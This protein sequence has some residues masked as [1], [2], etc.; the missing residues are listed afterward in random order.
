MKSININTKIC[1]FSIKKLHGLYTFVLEFKD[2]RLILVGENGTG[3][4]TCLKIF[5]YFITGQ[6]SRLSFYDFESLEFEFENANKINLPKSII[7]KILNI[8]N[9]YLRQLPPPVRNSIMHMSERGSISISDL[10]RICDKYDI[11][12]RVLLSE[13][14]NNHLDLFSNDN[15]EHDN[16]LADIHKNIQNQFKDINFIYLP[17]FRRIES[18]FKDIFNGVDESDLRR[19][20]QRNRLF[21]SDDSN[22]IELVEFGMKD[23]KSAIDKTLSDLIEFSRESLNKLT[24][25]YLGDIANK[26]YSSL[27]REQIQSINKDNIVEIVERADSKILSSGSKKNFL[28]ILENKDKETDFSEHELIMFHH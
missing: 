23:I 5:Y 26:E 28:Q 11:S 22:C 21:L 12:L 1:K 24:L 8:D 15:K 18:D 20:N 9:R 19:R 3:K 2:N 25:M 13:A 4:T 6:I 14:N 16:S 7:S 10:E 27:T 17:T